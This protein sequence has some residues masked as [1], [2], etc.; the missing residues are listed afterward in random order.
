MQQFKFLILLLF[1][2][3]TEFDLKVYF[4]ENCPS[5]QTS[6]ENYYGNIHR[7]QSNNNRHLSIKIEDISVAKLSTKE[8]QG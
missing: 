1:V 8:H 7:K 4:Y 3:N 2:A 5:Y 6:L